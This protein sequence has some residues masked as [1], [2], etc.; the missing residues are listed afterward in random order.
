MTPSEPRR[1]LASQGKPNTVTR[2]RRHDVAEPAVIPLRAM[3]S[4]SVPCARLALA[5]VVA[6][7][8]L[9]VAPARPAPGVLPF[10]H[11]DY[12]R[13]LAEA[14]ARKLPLFVESWAPW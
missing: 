4:T 10:I 1:V 7:M 9:G 12:A 11:D 6:A 2:Y 14:R 13:A 8:L 5:G 3:G